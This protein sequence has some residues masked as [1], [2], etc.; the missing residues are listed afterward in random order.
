M[1]TPGQLWRL[2]NSVTKNLL[3]FRKALWFHIYL[4]R[5]TMQSAV[6]SDRRG[7]LTWKMYIPART[8]LRNPYP[9][10]PDFRVKQQNI[11]SHWCLHY[12]VHFYTLSG[13]YLVFKILPLVAHFRKTLTFVALKLT[14]MVPQSSQ[15]IIEPRDLAI[16]S[17]PMTRTM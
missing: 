2:F 9:P 5:K 6:P 17:V 13:T 1:N 8:A 11:E 3:T 10:F 12:D 14:K 4:S 16:I 15:H 7:V